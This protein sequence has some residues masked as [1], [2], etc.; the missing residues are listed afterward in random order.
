MTQNPRIKKKNLLN[1]KTETLSM[2]AD[3]NDRIISIGLHNLGPQKARIK[4]RNFLAGVLV[5]DMERHQP[6]VAK[7]RPP[8]QAGIF[9]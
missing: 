6:G 5:Q 8:A 7:A 1:P 2:T 4:E 9:I 3:S